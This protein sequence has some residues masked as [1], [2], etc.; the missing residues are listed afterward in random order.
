AAAEDERR[1]E[2][3]GLD[4]AASARVVCPVRDGNDAILAGGNR[5]PTEFGDRTEDGISLF[6]ENA[7]RLARRSAINVWH[8]SAFPDEHPR[9]NLAAD[10]IHQPRARPG[11]LWQRD[12]FAVL[13]NRCL[14]EFQL[15]LDVRDQPVEI[16]G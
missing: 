12:F 14:V 4:D 9:G 15:P 10:E 5:F 11:Q 7:D 3:P 16:D 8:Q 2:F 6:I 1:G 13:E